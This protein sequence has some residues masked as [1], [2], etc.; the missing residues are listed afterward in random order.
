MDSQKTITND[1][2]RPTHHV[3]YG[4][5]DETLQRL[6]TDTNN[7]DTNDPRYAKSS[8]S[9]RLMKSGSLSTTPNW[10]TCWRSGAVP[11]RLLM[12]AVSV[13]AMFLLSVL[14][15]TLTPKPIVRSKEGAENGIAIPRAPIAFPMADRALYG[16]SAWNFIRVDLFHPH[17]LFEPGTNANRSHDG[18]TTTIPHTDDSKLD[19]IL[20]VPFPT[21]AFWMNFVM[22]PTAN[23]FSYPIVTYPYAFTW[24][25]TIL[26]VSYPFLRRRVDEYS[27]RD[28]VDPDISLGVVN[29]TLKRH[30]TS[31]DPLSVTLRF[32]TTTAT[33]RSSST[34]GSTRSGRS[35]ESDGSWETYLVHG[36]P[37]ITTKH[38]NTKP[39]LKALSTFPKVTCLFDGETGGGEASKDLCHQSTVS[40]SQLV[41]TRA[42]EM[43]KKTNLTY[44]RHRHQLSGD[45]GIEI[46]HGLQFLIHTQEAAA[47]LLISSDYI[48]LS[49]D[50][51]VRT[52]IVA[53]KPF[54]GVLR[55]AYIPLT[56]NVGTDGI[57]GLSSS[58]GLKR[59]VT[60]A[61]VYPTGGSVSWDFKATDVL[62]QARAEN[63]LKAF[64][65]K[66]SESAD[67][68][69]FKGTIG[70]VSLKYDTQMMNSNSNAELLMLGLP[71]HADVLSPDSMLSASQFD[72]QY[73]CIKGQM[74]PVVGSSWSYDEE[75][76]NTQFDRV[77]DIHL[78]PNVA[79][80]ILQNI[81]FDMNLFPTMPSLNIYGYGKQVARMAQLAHAANVVTKQANVTQVVLDEITHKLHESLV[82]L[83]DGNVDDELLY[84]TQLGGIVSKNGLKDANEDFGNGRYNDHHFHY[85]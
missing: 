51:R 57:S 8:E 62:S 16:D 81:K 39:L 69:T 76:T 25:E 1:A 42:C 31:F 17:L 28:V 47:W 9:E 43:K 6:K 48:E 79:N 7:D 18:P 74:V 68:T 61:A 36:S 72:L 41:A 65:G 80:L 84:D 44:C 26:Q 11:Q 13:V 56:S 54:S 37:Y 14:Y 27:I 3:V 85:G 52:T 63:A 30:V 38:V 60:H 49:F 50:T 71:H 53:T 22:E 40:K 10:K 77:P 32:T 66:I 35:T 33:A 20:N 46:L 21:G 70:T 45:D 78:D 34:T 59:L 24:S 55:L 82:A 64:S 73:W 19:P 58:T 5:T 75:L 15:T 83:L 23:G 67:T 2:A 4:S 29:P 12:V